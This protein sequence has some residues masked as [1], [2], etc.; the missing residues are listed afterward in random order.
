[1]NA[2]PDRDASE[3]AGRVAVVTGGT[4]GIGLAVAAELLRAG[5][6]VT[7]VSRKA[8]S[9]RDATAELAE[10]AGAERVLGLVAHVADE[11]AARLAIDETIDRLGRMDI[12]VNNAATNPYHGRL[13]GLSESAALKTAQVNQFAPLLWTGLA[14]DAWMSQHGGAVVNVASV[15]GLIVDPDIGFYNATKAALLLLTRQLA[16]ELGPKVRVNAVAPGLIKTELARVVWEARESILSAQLPLRRLG[17]VQ[18]VAHA[19]RFLVSDRASWITGQTLV[20]DGGALTLPI[21]VQQ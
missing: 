8:E 15:G 11:A 17:T 7:V 19:V 12:L 20:L 2:R 18:D 9:V 10:I 4:K 5:A 6:A 3:L 1:V 21:G 13:I 16:Y 14:W